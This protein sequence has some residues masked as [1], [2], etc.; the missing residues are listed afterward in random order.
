MGVFKAVNTENTPLDSV[1]S[2]AAKLNDISCNEMRRT[3]PP[4]VK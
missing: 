1:Y 2:P 3:F 4:K